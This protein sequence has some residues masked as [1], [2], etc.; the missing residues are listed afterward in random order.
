MAKILNRRGTKI[1][2]FDMKDKKELGVKFNFAVQ[3]GSKIKG[4]KTL[5]EVNKA[6]MWNNKALRVTTKSFKK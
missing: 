1:F 4:F 6:L 3:Q 5:T 2:K